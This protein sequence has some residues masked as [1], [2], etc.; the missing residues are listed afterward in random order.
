M[1]VQRPH[2]ASTAEEMA[3]YADAVLVAPASWAVATQ[4]PHL[5]YISATSPAYPRYIS[6]TSPLHLPHI[7]APSPPHL[8]CTAQALR[9][10]LRLEIARPRR[11]HRALMQLEALVD[12]LDPDKH[13]QQTFLGRHTSRIPP[14]Y[15]PRSP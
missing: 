1:S 11:R 3:P 6:A 14:A 9:T 5:A 12:N 10:R 4:A 2:H 13:G 15:L 7:S 8:P